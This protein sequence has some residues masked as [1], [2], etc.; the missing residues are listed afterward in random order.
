M[1]NIHTYTRTFHPLKRGH[2]SNKIIFWGPSGVLFRKFSLS[3]KLHFLKKQQLTLNVPI[4]HLLSKPLLQKTSTLDMYVVV[5]VFIHTYVHLLYTRTYIY[6]NASM[7]IIYIC[8]IMYMYI[9]MQVYTYVYTYV[10]T[11]TCIWTRIHQD[12]IQITPCSASSKL[13]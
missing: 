10:Y 13:L 9:Y 3:L 11:C 1:M 6:L 8:T 7:I 4:L 12:S 5:P 2:L